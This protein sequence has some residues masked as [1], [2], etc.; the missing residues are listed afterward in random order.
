MGRYSFTPKTFSFGGFRYE[1]DRFSGFVFQ[2]VVNT[3]L[4]HRFIED[5]IT[6]LTAQV[7]VGYKFSSRLDVITQPPDDDDDK[8]AGVAAVDFTHELSETTTIFNR[9][10]AE[11]TS[12]NKFLQNEIGFTV[13]VYNR[14]ALSLAYAVRHN[15]DPPQG[16]KR[17]DML[18]T[19][20]LVYER[21]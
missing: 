2:G 8:L 6:K 15:T 17:T 11:V 1:R 9:F 19:V 21:K 16:F 13:K 7:G 12:D 14:I 18:S 3:G 5:E 10:G 4:G 20:N